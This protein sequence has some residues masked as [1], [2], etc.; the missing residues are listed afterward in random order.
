VSEENDKEEERV[1]KELEEYKKAVE[2]RQDDINKLYAAFKAEIEKRQVS[3]SENFDKSI[4]TYSSW[5]LGISITFIKDFIPITVA[6]NPCYLYWSWYLFAAAIAITTISFLVSYKGLELSQKHGE[7]YFLEEDDAYLNRD[8]IFNIIV[9]KSNV[10]CAVIFLLALLFT[11]VFV[12]SNLEPAAILKA[13]EKE[14]MTKDTKKPQVISGIAMD[15]LPSV[16]MQ[17]R[18]AKP[19]APVQAKPAGSPPQPPTPPANGNG[20]N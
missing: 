12:A 3:S 17:T 8:N 2:K 5:A 18:P 10:L 19:V 9:K 7:K 16:F 15:G 13:K 11:I 14:N 6:K 20:S 4:L 1:K